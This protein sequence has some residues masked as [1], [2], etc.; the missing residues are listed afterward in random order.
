VNPATEE[1]FAQA[2]KADEELLELAIGA[3]RAALPAWQAIA[4]E[5]R[6]KLFLKL[7]ERIV[8]RADRYAELL[9]Q[10]A[11]K[12]I[13]EAELEVRM[14]IGMIKSGA[15]IG[16]I[17]IEKMHAA[18]G[19]VATIHRRPLGV[20]AGIT[21]WNMPLMQ[22]AMKLVQTLSTGN[23]LVLKVAPSAPLSG[24]ELGADALEVFPSGTV[25]VLADENE[26]GPLLVSHPGV[27]KVAFTGSTVTGR[28]IME[29]A[30][31][32]LKRITMELGGSDAAIVLEDVDVESVAK[33]LFVGAMFNCGQICT[34]PKRF[35]VADQ[36]YD[37]FCDALVARAKRATVGDPNDPQTRL[38][39]LQN[40]IQYEKV[41]G[42]LED[43]KANGVVCSGG[44]AL[45]RPGY[46]V[47]PTIVRDIED[48][49]RV[50]D[51]EQFGPIMP[52][53]RVKDEQDALARANRSPYGLG[54]SV[55]CAD[56]ERGANLAANLECGLAW[57]N[58]HNA[59]VPDAPYS[60]AKQSGYGV[61]GGEETIRAF[62]Q[63]SVVV[64]L[65]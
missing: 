41:L 52:I 27:A 34:A 59:M 53:V 32:T 30:A 38:G 36:I 16:K 11:G 64:T 1:T 40:R 12:P 23:C 51:E 22:P 45:D 26:L 37:Q 57:V 28:R 39:P 48:G 35:Y 13:R 43:A 7:A 4:V 63:V 50:V 21:P 10:E 19:R 5:N 6:Q 3:A 47:E 29:S 8:E 54:G 31:P 14:A 60:G 46:F 44:K 24:L 49:A 42:Y 17:A 25:N 18:D 20:V 2:P 55:W 62:T 65:S 15:A 33:Q 9:I 56:Q 61:E 58:A